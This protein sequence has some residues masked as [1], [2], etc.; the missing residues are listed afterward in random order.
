LKASRCLETDRKTLV[1]PFKEYSMGRNARRDTITPFDKGL[2]LLAFFIEGFRNVENGQNICNIQEQSCF[3]Q[4]GTRTGSPPESEDEFKWIRL[5][6][7]TQET[8]R[9]E[10]EWIWVYLFVVNNGPVCH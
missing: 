5:R 2:N 3:G 10:M 9:I 4:M 7:V 1:L 6:F 8:S